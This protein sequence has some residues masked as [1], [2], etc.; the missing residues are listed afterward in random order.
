LEDWRRIFVP[1]EDGG[2]LRSDGHREGCFFRGEGAPL[3]TQ[4]NGQDIEAGL[5]RL[6]EREEAVAVAV[7]E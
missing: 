6:E 1:G 3:P 2:Y 7:A 5:R 4:I